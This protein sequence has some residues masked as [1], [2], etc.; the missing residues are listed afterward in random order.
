MQYADTEQTWQSVY[1]NLFVA[2]DDDVV[3]AAVD[4]DLVVVVVVVPM[5]SIHGFW[6]AKIY[7]NG[8]H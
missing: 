2:V 1:C 6:H 4:D 7:T 5:L 3:V 8:C